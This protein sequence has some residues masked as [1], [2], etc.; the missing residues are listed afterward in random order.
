MSA[1]AGPPCSRSG[2]QGVRGALRGQEREARK[3]N[4]A[5]EWLQEPAP[6]A[7][8]PLPCRTP[9]GSRRRVLP[10]LL[11]SKPDSQDSSPK[12]E[13]RSHSFLR[14]RLLAA[15]GAGR[16]AADLHGG[17]RSPRGRPVRVPVLHR[18]RATEAEGMALAAVRRGA[19]PSAVGRA[20]RIRPGQLAHGCFFYLAVAQD[21]LD[22]TLSPPLPNAVTT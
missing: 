13:G 20:L 8:Q 6:P 22:R 10:I 17:L 18:R 3:G 4:P 21:S 1:G 11:E 5:G 19:P 16:A 12:Q 7:P 2:L 9:H 14:R 15:S